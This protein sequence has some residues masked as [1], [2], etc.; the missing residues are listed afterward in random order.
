MKILWKYLRPHRLLIALSLLLAG[1]AQL[2][3]LLDPIIFGHIID[4]YATNEAE[5]SEAQLIK[6]ISYWLLIALAIAVLARLC[7]ALQDFV[8]R[9]AVAR[10]GM[11]IFNDGLKQTLRL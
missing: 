6:E 8:T 7:K 9:K 11:Q 2:L 4:Q 10:F 1:S 3:T 5:L